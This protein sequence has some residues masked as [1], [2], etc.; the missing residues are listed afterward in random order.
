METPVAPNSAEQA[1][2]V[3]HAYTQLRDEIEV[4]DFIDDRFNEVPINA[5]NLCQ[6]NPAATDCSGEP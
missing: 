3:Q 4:A 5:S 2:N 1:E 6:P